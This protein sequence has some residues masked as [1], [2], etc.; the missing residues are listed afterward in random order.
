MNA[1]DRVC[2]VESP[3]KGRYQISV[4]DRL[5]AVSPEARARR[6]AT[7]AQR[8]ADHSDG[9]LSPRG[10]R[11]LVPEAIA[12]D[13]GISDGQVRAYL[14]ARQRDPGG[15]GRGHAR[16]GNGRPVATKGRPLF[17]FLD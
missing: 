12:D 3:D 9:V 13:L 11:R 16:E 10:E 1:P 2:V 7:L 5:K 8:R 15:A 14:S 6:R 17:A 4:E